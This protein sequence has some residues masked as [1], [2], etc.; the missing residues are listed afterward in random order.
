MAAD[1]QSTTSEKCPVY[2]EVYGPDSHKNPYPPKLW[3]QWLERIKIALLA[4]HDMDYDDLLKDPAAHKRVS[5]PKTHRTEESDTDREARVN[6]NQQAMDYRHSCEAAWE[7]DYGKTTRRLADKRVTSMLYMALGTEAQKK[8][9]EKLNDFRLN[10]YILA[11][12]HREVTDIFM[13]ARGVKIERLALFS[14]RYGHNT[15]AGL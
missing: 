8:V 12:F 9:E 15:Q 2:N 3:T 6:A 13:Q 1:D 7:A 14:A 5:I 4:K 10:D 11:M